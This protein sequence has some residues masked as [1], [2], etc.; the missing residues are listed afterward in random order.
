MLTASLFEAETSTVPRL[1]ESW[2]LTCE[3]NGRVVQQ[4]PVVVDRGQTLRV[5]LRAC[6]RR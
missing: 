3:R 1:V 2:T 5:D 6:G 4:V